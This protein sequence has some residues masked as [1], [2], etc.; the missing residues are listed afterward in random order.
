MQWKFPL[1]G[2]SGWLY[3]RSP[4]RYSYGGR[5]GILVANMVKIPC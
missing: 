5:L 1:M 4:E 2:K 3:W